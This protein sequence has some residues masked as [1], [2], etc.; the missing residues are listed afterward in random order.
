[1]SRSHDHGHSKVPAL[2]LNSKKLRNAFYI[3]ICLSVAWKIEKGYFS[4]QK[5]FGNREKLF[6]LFEHG[7]VVYVV[8]VL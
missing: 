1:M 4:L 6:C 7:D 8:K 2:D 5:I 3:G